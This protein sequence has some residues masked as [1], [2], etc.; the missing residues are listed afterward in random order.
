MTLA[1]LIR[2]IIAFIIKDILFKRLQVLFRGF[3]SFPN[4]N[5]RHNNSSTL[6]IV[7]ASFIVQPAALW[8][9]QAALINKVDQLCVSVTDMRLMIQ[10]ETRGHSPFGGYE[11]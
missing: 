5:T 8:F 7:L 10:E 11:L 9:K 1:T 6:E 4:G 2:D 3:R